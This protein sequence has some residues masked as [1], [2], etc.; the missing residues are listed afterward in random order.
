MIK[1]LVSLCALCVILYLTFIWGV[2]GVGMNETVTTI[3]YIVLM[4]VSVMVFGAIE[5]IFGDDKDE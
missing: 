3:G 5:D 4:L 2:V 1:L